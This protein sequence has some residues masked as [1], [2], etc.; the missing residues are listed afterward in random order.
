MIDKYRDHDRNLLLHD[1]NTTPMPYYEFDFIS[2][3]KASTI[4]NTYFKASECDQ[5]S[6]RG[7]HST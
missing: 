4:V 2:D 1:N 7:R 6:T 3:H 5:R